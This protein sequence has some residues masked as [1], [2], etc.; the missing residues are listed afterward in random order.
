MRVLSASYVLMVFSSLSTVSLAQTVALWPFDEQQG[1]YPSSVLSDVS[2]NDYPL[3]LGLGGQVVPG[4]F[5]NA[6][7][8]G[9]Y[10][11]FPFPK[12]DNPLFGLGPVATRGG[13]KVEPLTWKTA[14]FCALMTSGENHLRNE[15]G[16][17][18]ATE[19]KLNLGDFD[20]TVEFWFLPVRKTAIEGVVFEVGRGPR[21]DSSEV[22]QLALTP[23]NRT[24]VLINQPTSTRLAST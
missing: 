20:W 11:A 10:P 21:G 2:S 4:K 3:V 16:F 15:V 22:T 5:G 24:F 9:D 1:L 6:L 8:P 12:S 7:E 14:R 13:R 19:T 18:N 23:D 17:A